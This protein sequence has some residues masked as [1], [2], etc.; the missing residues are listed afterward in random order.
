M[1][2]GQVLN[3]G[4]S[5]E[6]LATVAR[7]GQLHVVIKCQVLVPMRLMVVAVSWLEAVS[8][9]RPEAARGTE[10]SEYR[11]GEGVGAAAPLMLMEATKPMSKG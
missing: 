7:P 8:R 6:N 4:I 5:N 3:A 9:A 11:T 1:Q 10:H 2:S